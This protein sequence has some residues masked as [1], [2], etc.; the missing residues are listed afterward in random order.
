MMAVA[1]DPAPAA[2]RRRAPAGAQGRRSRRRARRRRGCSASA[3]SSSLSTTRSARQPG[4]DARRSAAAER[5]RAAARRRACHSAVA[6]RQRRRRRAST[7]RRRSAQPLRPFELAQLRERIDD[8]VRIAADA[9][10]A[11]VRSEV[12]LGAGNVPSPRSASV[13]GARPATAPLAASPSTSRSVMCV[14]CTMHQRSSTPAC[15]EQPFDR[16]H[17]APRVALV[18]LARLLG[19]VD[20]DRRIRRRRSRTTWPSSSGVHGAQA[21]RRDAEH[22]AVPRARRASALDQRARTIAACARSGAGAP[23]AACR[24]SRRARRTPAAA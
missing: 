3:G 23:S 15:V 17:A 24:R 8:G 12:R 21:V 14:A 22:V 6:D 13:V 7:L 10:A 1:H 9:E 16:T 19:D 18:H 5:L 11:A 20:V 2:H 4:G